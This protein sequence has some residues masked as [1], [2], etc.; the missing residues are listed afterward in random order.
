MYL[1]LRMEVQGIVA[2][3]MLFPSPDRGTKPSMIFSIIQRR[4]S[5][6]SKNQKITKWESISTSWQTTIMMKHPL[7]L[8]LHTQLLQ[9]IPSSRRITITQSPEILTSK[10][11]T[12]I[13]RQPSLLT[14]LSSLTVQATR[15]WCLHQGLQATLLKITIPLTITLVQN[16]MGIISLSNNAQL[17]QPQR[18]TQNLMESQQHNT[19]WH[20]RWQNPQKKKW[21]LY[22][23]QQHESPA[24]WPQSPPLLVCWTQTCDFSLSW[25]SYLETITPNLW[26]CQC[27][28]WVIFNSLFNQK[29]VIGVDM[30]VL[31]SALTSFHFFL[32]SFTIV[33]FVLLH[34]PQNIKQCYTNV[35]ALWPFKVPKLICWLWKNVNKKMSF[36][37]TCFK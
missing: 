15:T 13:Q 35:P 22:L 28:W 25:K 9:L 27:I 2:D 21:E 5:P 7:A 33:Y 34:F 3:L 12:K 24:L 36:K 31:A 16:S 10:V 37:I 26:H 4:T 23:S 30:H 32:T 8:S 14:S 19:W 18:Y 11:T 20:S 6:L 29:L 17:L 1:R